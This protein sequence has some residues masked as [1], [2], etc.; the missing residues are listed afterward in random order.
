MVENFKNRI[1]G[2]ASGF[3]SVFFTLLITNLPPKEQKFKM[4]GKLKKKQII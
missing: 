3:E 2:V 4:A 1:K